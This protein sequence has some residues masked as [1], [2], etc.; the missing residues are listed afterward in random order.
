MNPTYLI[1][2]GICF[3]LLVVNTPSLTSWLGKWFK[4]TPTSE[5]KCVLTQ[6]V[7]TISDSDGKQKRSTICTEDAK[8]LLD[9]LNENLNTQSK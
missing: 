7:V 6:Y 4:K 5:T 3:I 2:A 9:S 8:K 1:A